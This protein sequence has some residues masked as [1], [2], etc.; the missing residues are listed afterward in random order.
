MYSF[1]WECLVNNPQSKICTEINEFT[2][3]TFAKSKA[4]NQLKHVIVL[5]ESDIRNHL[6]LVIRTMKK[7]YQREEKSLVDQI[8]VNIELLGVYVEIDLSLQMFLKLLNDE[9]TR[10]SPRLI[11]SLLVNNYNIIIY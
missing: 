7:C 1:K 5:A 2:T 3:T 6:E 4:L 10:A 8:K 9:E 11:S